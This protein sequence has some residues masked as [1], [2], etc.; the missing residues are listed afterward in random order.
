MI[1]T[2]PSDVELFPRRVTNHDDEAYLIEHIVFDDYYD[3]Q[4]Y[5]A[6]KAMFAEEIDIVKQS[7][8]IDL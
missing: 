7:K 8:N 6:A 5:L 4:L 3:T 1:G 2:S